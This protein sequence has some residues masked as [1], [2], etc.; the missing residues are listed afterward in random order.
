MGLGVT[1]ISGASGRKLA[2]SLAVDPLTVPV[3]FR[4]GAPGVVHIT[5]LMKRLDGVP[6][7]KIDGRRDAATL[8]MQLLQFPWRSV[9]GDQ[10]LQ[11]QGGPAPAL[12][13]VFRPRISYEAIHIR[14]Q[15]G[16][17]AHLFTTK[18]EVNP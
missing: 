3:P 9:Y 4:K 7:T 16:Q 2:M 17:R 13:V 12:D 5:E 8:A 15:D 18:P 11:E 14:I 6:Q 10:S 1:A